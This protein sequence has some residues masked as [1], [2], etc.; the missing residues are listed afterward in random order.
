MAIITQLKNPPVV[1]FYFVVPDVGAHLIKSAQ[2]YTEGGKVV[3][4]PDFGKT[5]VVQYR[6]ELPFREFKRKP[7]QEEPD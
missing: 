5:V 2:P 3:A 6:L 4:D 7:E 1:E